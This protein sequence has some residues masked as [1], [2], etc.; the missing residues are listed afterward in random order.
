MHLSNHFLKQSHLDP[1]N[2]ASY[3]PVANLTFLSKVVERVVSIRLQKYLNENGLQDSFQS[4]YREMH[5]V[6][7]A[8]LRVQ[9]DILTEMDKGN[10]VGLILLDLSGA[11]DTV[12]HSI[13]EDRL[14]LTGIGGKALLWFISYLSHRSQ[15]VCVRSS[16]SKAISLNFSVPQGSVLGPQLFKIYTLPLRDII[17]RHHLDYHIY[18]DDTHIYFSCPPVQAEM[19]TWIARIEACIS[20]IRRWMQ[21][22][23]LKLNDDKT[24][25]LLL[26]SRQ[27]LAKFKV[28]SVQIGTTSVPPVERARD[29]GVIF[30]SNMTM[31]HQVSNCVK[32]AYHSLRNLRS[33]RKYLTK[34][35]S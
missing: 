14:Q 34:K 18:A 26:G 22:S 31:E 4:A 3:R 15:A 29:L 32:R 11:F 25:F 21:E 12:D 2:L 33:I 35:G 23:Y 13:L 28:H 19:N 7:T 9:N 16:T 6:E 10:V 30:D 24:E 8:L 20:D 27:Q 5:S 17:K 1:Q